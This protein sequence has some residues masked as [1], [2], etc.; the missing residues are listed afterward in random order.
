MADHLAP[1]EH[2]D[3][4]LATAK[5]ADRREQAA[6]GLDEA[7]GDAVSGKT[8]TINMKRGYKWSD[9][10]PVDANDVIFDIDLIKAAVKESAANEL[11]YTPGLF[12]DNVTSMSTKG[13]YTVVLHLNKKYNPSFFT[14]E[15]GYRV[16]SSGSAA[17]GTRFTLRENGRLL[18]N[19]FGVLVYQRPDL[20]DGYRYKETGVTAIDASLGANWTFWEKDVRAVA[21]V[22]RVQ[23]PL[24]QVVGDPWLAE[25]WAATAGVSVTAF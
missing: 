15:D 13:K 10:K 7:K 2:D 8:V 22:T 9:G 25:N 3:A 4:P 12:P 23:V 17:A 14:P 18:F 6:N 19:V 1:G 24:W 16:G 20:W 11:A 21:L 5:Q